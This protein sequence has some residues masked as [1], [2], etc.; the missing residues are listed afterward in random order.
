MELGIET[1]KSVSRHFLSISRDS[2]YLSLLQTYLQISYFFSLVSD[3]NIV[4][5]STLPRSHTV[6]IICG[7]RQAFL[8]KYLLFLIWDTEQRDKLLNLSLSNIHPN[9]ERTSHFGERYQSCFKFRAI[10]FLLRLLLVSSSEVMKHLS[11]NVQ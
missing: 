5:L 10:F 3:T 7:L 11:L 8:F 4:C 6:L 9:P 2:I 1:L